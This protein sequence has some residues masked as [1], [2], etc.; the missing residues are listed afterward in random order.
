M[1]HDKITTPEHISNAE[2]YELAGDV[3]AAIRALVPLMIDV[4]DERS[5]I[6]RAVSVLY[7]SIGHRVVIEDRKG[8]QY[9]LGVWR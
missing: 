5:A 1:K 2:S 8:R 4:H 7:Q 6:E 9:E 3:V